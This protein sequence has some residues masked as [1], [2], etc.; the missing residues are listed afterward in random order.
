MGRETPFTVFTGGDISFEGT[1]IGTFGGIE[2]IG[3]DPNPWLY[4]ISFHVSR[5]HLKKIKDQLYRVVARTD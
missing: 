5:E 2:P 3:P 4:R 1:P